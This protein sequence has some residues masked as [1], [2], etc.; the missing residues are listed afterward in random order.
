[1]PDE[2][3]IKRLRSLVN[4]VKF[5]DDVDD[6]VAFINT[7]S[8]ERVMFILSNA[9]AQS[10]LPRIE[11]LQQIYKIYLLEDPRS[12]HLSDQTLDSSRVKGLYQSLNEISAQMSTDISDETRDLISYVSVSPNGSS[13]DPMFVYIRLINEIIL[14]DDETDK[15]MQDLIDFARE[16]YQENDEELLLIDEFQNDYRAER[17][18]WWFTRSCFLSKVEQPLTREHSVHV[19]PFRC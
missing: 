19:R 5:F 17:A 2:A 9:F 7:I 6:C 16:E 10:I 1:M 18:V 8:S 12:A 13:T 4:Y 3:M 11:D 14:D 15:S